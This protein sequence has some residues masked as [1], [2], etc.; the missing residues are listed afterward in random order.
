MPVAHRDKDASFDKTVQ[1][2]LQRSCLAPGKL[3]NRGFAANLGIM[4][5]NLLRTSRGNDPR[6]RLPRNFRKG[7]INNVWVSK[8]Q[9]QKGLDC[10]ELLRPTKLKQHDC[11]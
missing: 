11:K 6:Q 3:Q 5:A 1:F 7:K 10:R 2:S 4:V 9:Q 8:Q